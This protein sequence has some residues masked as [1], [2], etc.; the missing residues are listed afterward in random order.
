LPRT[1]GHGRFLPR[2]SGFV[3]IKGL[4]AR[5]A[6]D[7]SGAAMECR[8]AFDIRPVGSVLQF[9][10]TARNNTAGAAAKTADL[11]AQSNND[12]PSIIIVEYHRR[13][14]GLRRRRLRGEER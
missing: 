13:I 6:S 12:R 9:P 3:D 1:S 5:S 14:P 8:M 2:C 4:L 7:M 11:P 10:L